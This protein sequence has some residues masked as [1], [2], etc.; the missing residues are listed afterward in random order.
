[1]IRNF[2]KNVRSWNIVAGVPLKDRPLCA[3]NEQKHLM[4]ALLQEECAEYQAAM[5]KKCVTGVAD[6]LGDIIVICAST[7]A[8][9][10]IDL[11]PVVEE[12]MRSN[13]T[14]FKI[15]PKAETETY[16]KRLAQLQEKNP[17]IKHIRYTVIGKT[18]YEV[19]MREDKKITKHPETYKPP[20]LKPLLA[21]YPENYLDNYFASEAMKFLTANGLPFSDTHVKALAQKLKQT[22]GY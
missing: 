9:Y 3:E 6:A 16:W 12:I 4:V 21:G 20:K 13:W 11:A 10:G 7:A 18:T 22:S 8:Q 1:M 19:V 2:L 17:D 5:M 14:K 15:V